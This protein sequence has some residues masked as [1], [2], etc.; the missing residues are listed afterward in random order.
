VVVIVDA[1]AVEFSPG[2]CSTQEAGTIADHLENCVIQYGI[3]SF[4]ASA[5]LIPLPFSLPWDTH[6]LS[7]Y[8][9]SL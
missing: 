7:V 2:H 5:E 4:D 3:F 6:K 9:T 8:R 1:G